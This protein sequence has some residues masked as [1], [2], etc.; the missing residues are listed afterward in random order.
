MKFEVS[1]SQKTEVIDITEDIQSNIEVE[2]GVCTV[3]VPHT[4]AGLTVNENEDRLVDDIENFLEENV[5][6]KDYRHDEIDD[7]ASS[8]LRN[9]LLNSSISIPVESGKLQLGTWQSIMFV[10]L[11]GP[12]NRTVHLRETS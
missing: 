7:N 12:R 5:P 1:S 4:T 3:F 11:D 8:H 10:E 2:D 6:E 9:L